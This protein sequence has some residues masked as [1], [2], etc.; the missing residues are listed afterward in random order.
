MNKIQEFKQ[1]MMEK[2]C[3]VSL[4]IFESSNNRCALGFLYE[5]MIHLELYTQ[6]TKD[7]TNK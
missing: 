5:P 3:D 1:T 7:T 4:K 6:S 2:V